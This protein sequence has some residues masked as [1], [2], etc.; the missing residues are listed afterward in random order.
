MRHPL[1]F[2]KALINKDVPKEYPK[3][4]KYPNRFLIAYLSRFLLPKTESTN[5]SSF[6][7]KKHHFLSE[8]PASR[9]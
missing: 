8:I 6:S 1:K 5:F 2:F 4:K 7:K 3:K 9:D